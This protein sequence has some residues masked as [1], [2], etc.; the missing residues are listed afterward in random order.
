MH[1]Y[2]CHF[3]FYHF[4]GPATF[5]GEDSCEFHVHGGCA[6]VADMLEALGTIPN[7]SSA[8]P[9]QFTKRYEFFRMEASFF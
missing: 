6:V 4:S 9:G 3:R 2:L 1:E 5:T 8:D 7:F